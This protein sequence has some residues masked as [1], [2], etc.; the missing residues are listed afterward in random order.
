[1]RL[2]KEELAAIVREVIDIRDEG[3]LNVYEKFGK[4]LLVV[5]ECVKAWDD[6]CLALKASSSSDPH[7]H[8]RP[9]HQHWLALSEAIE[10]LRKL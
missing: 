2:S 9:E 10:K 7:A 5:K 6:Y 4:D 3:I 8:L 1:M